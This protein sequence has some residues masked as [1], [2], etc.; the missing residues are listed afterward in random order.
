MKLC[1]KAFPKNC[2]CAEC[3]EFRKKIPSGEPVLS[4]LVEL[5][6]AKPEDETVHV[7]TRLV[8]E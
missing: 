8:L 7:L 4:Q 2:Q 1:E 6:E 3:N 5:P